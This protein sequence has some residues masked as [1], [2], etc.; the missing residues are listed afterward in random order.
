M[1]KYEILTKN[2][3]KYV[4]IL[5]NNETV[6]VEAGLMHYYHGDISMTNPSPDTKEF[7][8]AKLSKE[9]IFR[10][11]FHGTGK[12][13]LSPS[14]E[15]YYAINLNNEAYII[16][17]GAFCA[18]DKDI[19]IDI[20]INKPFTGFFSGEG[21]VQTLVKGTGTVIISVPGQVEAIDLNDDTLVADGAFI[22]ARSKSL[23]FQTQQLTS[24]TFSTMT[25]G[26]GMVNV[27]KGTGTVFIAPV[28]NKNIIFKEHFG[29]ALSQIN[30]GSLKDKIKSKY[31]LAGCFIN[32]L[33]IGGFSIVLYLIIVKYFLVN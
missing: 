24:S 22:V 6:I 10:P 29:K 18:A 13:V 8:K 15:D 19:T 23:D 7:V 32:I 5:M 25:S 28:P 2:D 31:F 4:E 26:E 21:V 16:D 14:L 1:A 9:K 20:F 12:L 30:T 11:C 17:K 3:V 33:T 27:V